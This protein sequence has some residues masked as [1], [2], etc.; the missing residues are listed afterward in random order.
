MTITVGDINLLAK[1]K[2]SPWQLTYS[3]GRGLQSA[4]LRIWNGKKENIAMAQKEF[5]KRGIS[6][7]KASQGIY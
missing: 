7:S 1:I 4:P 2:K 5:E 6:A 3:Y